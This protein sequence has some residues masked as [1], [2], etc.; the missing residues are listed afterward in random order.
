MLFLGLLILTINI[1]NFD[2]LLIDY[3]E[4]IYSFII[5]GV[6]FYDYKKAKLKTNDK[7]D[8]FLSFEAIWLLIMIKYAYRGI[9]LHES[10]SIAYVVVWFIIMIFAYFTKDKKSLLERIKESE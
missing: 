6:I 2:N 1:L 9:T 8:Y 3:F 7:N 5:I 10:E 4:I